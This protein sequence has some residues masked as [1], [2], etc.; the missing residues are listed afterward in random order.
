MALALPDRSPRQARW[1]GPQ[2]LLVV[3]PQPTARVG[4][5]EAVEP[6]G[7]TIVAEAD[8]A[9]TAIEAAATSRPALCVLALELPGGGLR[10]IREMATEAPDTAIVALGEPGSD[11][12]ALHALR[13]GAIGYLRR[14]RAPAHLAD[15]LAGAIE[16]H[17]T[18]PRD[19][20]LRAAEGHGTRADSTLARSDGRRVPLTAR[21]RQ[22]VEHL[23]DGATTAEIAAA[24]ELSPITVR[25]HISEV[26][27]KVGARSRA[28][29]EAK[30]RDH[31]LTAGRVAELPSPSGDQ[32]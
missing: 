23:G 4:I 3:D 25:R 14:S 16:G 5:R 29:L 12:A 32:R 19:L 21:E 7:F 8:S 26:V 18:L 9:E 17:V 13:A 27:R 28:R 6:Y 11:D 24:L 31:S 15:V 10:A 2:S 1:Q 30:L 22:V 20:V